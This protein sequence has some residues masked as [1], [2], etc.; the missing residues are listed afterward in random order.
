MTLLSVAVGT[1]REVMWNHEAVLTSIFKTPING[2]VRVGSTNIVGDEQSDLT[3]HGGPEK[4][5]YAYPS[6]HYAIWQRELA[7]DL[8]PWASFGENLTTRGLRESVVSIGD[9]YRIGTAEFI[10]TQPRLPCFKLGIRLGR[11]DIVARF[12]SVDRSGFYFGIEREGEIGA[13][14]PIELIERDPRGLSVA[15]VY[16]LKLGGGTPERTALAAE[17]PALAAGWRE[18]FKR[19]VEALGQ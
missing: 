17:H 12:T 19:R 10:V 6:E 8:L 18:N 4:A 7:V 2:R 14:D 15:E 9:R 16:R 1:P 11:P 13:G 5:V 3:V